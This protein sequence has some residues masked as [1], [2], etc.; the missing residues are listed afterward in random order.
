MRTPLMQVYLQLFF[1][2]I[3]LG[4]SVAMFMR[5]NHVLVDRANLFIAFHVVTNAS[6]ALADIVSTISLCVYLQ[7]A[8]TDVR[9]T[10]TI[11]RRLIA[12]IAQRGALVSVVQTALLIVFLA[13]PHSTAWTAFHVNIS[14]IYSVTFFA[15]L[16][17]RRNVNEK[18]VVVVSSSR[19]HLRSQ[20]P[21]KDVISFAERRVDEGIS[22][23]FSQSGFI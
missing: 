14:K 21:R 5:K 11:V 9:R 4:C 19:Y 6:S 22:T 23:Q 17:N 13:A 8:R 18:D 1:A 3:A 7:G 16:N 2:G 15:M 20:A 10:S 12:F